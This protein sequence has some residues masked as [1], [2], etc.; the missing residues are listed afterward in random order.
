MGL[1]KSDLFVVSDLYEEKYLA[2]VLQN[3]LAVARIAQSIR[4]YRGPLL[5]LTVTH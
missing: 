5:A 2:A 1:R 3:V 4:S